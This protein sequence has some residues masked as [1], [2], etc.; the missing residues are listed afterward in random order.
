MTKTDQNAQTAAARSAPTSAVDR[1]VAA[2]RMAALDAAD[3]AYLGSEDT[4]GEQFGVSAPTLRQAA[5]LLEHEQVLRVKRGVSGGYY[6]RRPSLEGI[7]HVAGVYLRGNPSSLDEVMVVMRP[8]TPVLVDQVIRSLRGGAATEALD[9]FAAPT[10]AARLTPSED[11]AARFISLL[12]EM[13]R[14]GPLQLILRIFYDFGELL[15]RPATAEEHVLERRTAQ[16][17]AAA[18]QALLAENADAALAHLTEH[19][20]LIVERIK[21]RLNPVI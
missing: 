9:A 16:A 6:A 14:N 1:I 8:L 7:A 20:S 11:D 21:R 17:R 15:P 18:A 5:R 2:L 4:L 12:I 13:T 10:A 19:Q 3:G